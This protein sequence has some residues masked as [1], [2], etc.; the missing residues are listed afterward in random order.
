MLTL[1]IRDPEAAYLD[2]WLWLPKHKVSAQTLRR[3]LH[4]TTAD[5]RIDIKLW[6][7]SEHHFGIPRRKVNRTALPYDV[8]DL[9]PAEYPEAD[10]ESL[11]TL[12]L[13]DQGKTTQRDAY[14][15][16]QDAQEGILNVACGGG[17]TV[18]LLHAAAASRHPA[19]IITDKANILHQWKEEALGNKVESPKLRV[20]G[21]IGWIQGN[22]TKWKWR[23]CPLVFA[24]LKTLSMYANAVTPEMSAY[25]GTIIWDEVHHLAAAYFARTADLFMGRRLGASATI[26]R[27]DGMELVYL[28]HLGDVFY[29]NLEQDL[30][31]DV[32][33]VPSPTHIDLSSDE[34][35]PQ[36]ETCLGEVHH[37]KLCA[38]VGMR[39][40]ELN[41]AQE[42]LDREIADDRDVLAI[43]VSKDHAR[44]LHQRYPGSGVLD[45]DVK[46]TERLSVLRDHTLTFSTVDMAREALNKKSLDSLVILTE[47]SSSNTL[48]QAVGR[49]QRDCDAKRIPRVIVVHHTRIPPMNGMGMQLKRHFTKRGME[50]R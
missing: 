37:R 12:D 23:G 31:P 38:Y 3:S 14:A 18:V 40:E 16:L 7:E 24:T 25:F 42:V 39:P 48:Q 35:R 9:R 21:E 27:P 41:F 11:I 6:R 49:V 46:D 30:L 22:P 17:K 45:A 47:F 29:Q 4:L 43:A 19:L 13:L 8:V 28:W 10:L 15:A 34:V 20:G 33:F 44:A 5:G 36:I 32:Y 2:N 26:N 1:P 50:V